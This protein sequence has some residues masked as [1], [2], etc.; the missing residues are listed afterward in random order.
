VTSEYRV[1]PAGDTALVVE[2]GDGV[3]RRLSLRVLAL[4]RRL[5]E[6]QL[7]GVL[8]TVPTFRSL[9]VYFEPLVISA[10]ALVARIAELMPPTQLGD[11][12]GRLWRL[13][14]CYD[15]GVAP[16]LGDVATT[17]GLT[18]AQIIERHSGVTYHVY[19]LGFLPGQA[20]MG[21]VPAE[22][23]LPRRQVPRPRIPAGSLA[24]A[25]AMT[26]I[27]PLETPCG[28][29]IIGRSPIP[30]WQGGDRQQALLAPGDKVT[31]APVSLREY[32]RLAAQVAAG[33]LT[34]APEDVVLGAAA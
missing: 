18:S 11:A 7:D 24:I 20:Y 28:W 14:A 34:L 17:T 5:D 19:M 3:D 4:A 22:L 29:N 31:F 1:L 25:A 12:P 6:V 27:F 8:E 2:F 9:L 32:E 13:P 16:D 23:A 21:D 26:C 30:L 10:E 15:A 33:E